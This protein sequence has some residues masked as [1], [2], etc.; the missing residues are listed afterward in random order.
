[1][2]TVTRKTAA[3]G[4]KNKYIPAYTLTYKNGYLET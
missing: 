4:Q 1:M 3:L 2:A